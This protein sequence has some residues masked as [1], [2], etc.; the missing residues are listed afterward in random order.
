MVG[1]DSA[2]GTAANFQNAERWLS[3]LSTDQA[4]QESYEKLA[5]SWLETDSDS[6][7]AWIANSPL[8]AEAKQRLLAVKP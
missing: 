2:Y 7:R 8:S 5:K 6:A 3:Q 4:R 1:I